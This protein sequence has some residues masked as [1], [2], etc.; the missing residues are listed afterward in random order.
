MISIYDFILLSCAV[1]IVLAIRHHNNISILAT[2]A[3]INYCQLA[4]V[5]ILDHNTLFKGFKIRRSSNSLCCLERTY[6]F[7]FSS[8][9][10][11]RYKGIIVMLGKQSKTIELDAFKTNDID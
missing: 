4:G 6:Q 10:D 11:Q 3:A 1:S 7:E 2:Q 9:G 8:V 5:Q